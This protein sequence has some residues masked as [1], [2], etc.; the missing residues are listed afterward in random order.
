MLILAVTHTAAFTVI[1][2]W[3]TISHHVSPLVRSRPRATLQLRR[4]VTTKTNVLHI[5]E[6]EVLDKGAPRRLY[7]GGVADLEVL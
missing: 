4:M 3:P 7:I 6:Y 5:T 2:S 1:D